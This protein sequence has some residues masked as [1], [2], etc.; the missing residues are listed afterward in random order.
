M[1]SRKAQQGLQCVV[2][3]IAGRRVNRVLEGQQRTLLAIWLMISPAVSQT[4]SHSKKGRDQVDRRAA[5]LATAVPAGR[6]KIGALLLRG[7]LCLGRD[8]QQSS[9]IIITETSLLRLR[10]GHVF[11]GVCVHK[12]N[13]TCYC[14]LYMHCMWHMH[15]EDTHSQHLNGLE[16]TIIRCKKP[17][18][19]SLRTV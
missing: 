13:V 10:A 18:S 7:S 3:G 17:T 9:S 14:R 1:A 8:W 6:S 11:G 16:A 15:V 5:R 12:Y 19:T 2:H 4:L